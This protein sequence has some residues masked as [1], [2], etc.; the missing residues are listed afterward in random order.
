MKKIIIVLIFVIIILLIIFLFLSYDRDERII[1]KNLRIL[2]A[3]TSKSKDDNNLTLIAKTQ[4]IQS[5]FTDECRVIVEYKQ[6]PEIDNL[7]ELL[8]VYQQYFR[9]VDDIKVNFY[10]TSIR[11]MNDRNSADVLMTAKATGTD[12]QDHEK[13]SEA[14]EVQ[15]IWKKIDNKWKIAEVKALKTLH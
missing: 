2:K 12:P 13:I 11:I 5:L 3:T 7:N 6:I 14:R 9:L 10:D 1:R 15:M 4:K 8:A